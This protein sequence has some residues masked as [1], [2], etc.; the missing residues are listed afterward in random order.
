MGFWGPL[1]S[2]S[3]NG[4][5]HVCLCVVVLQDDYLAFLV[6][7]VPLGR[8]MK[9]TCVEEPYA[10][11]RMAETGLSCGPEALELRITDCVSLG[12]RWYFLVRCPFLESARTAEKEEGKQLFIC[13]TL[14]LRKQ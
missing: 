2:S 7:K 12:W 5:H 10:P 6:G 9:A 13:L 14:N 1:F 3:H 11:Q 8:E 4:N